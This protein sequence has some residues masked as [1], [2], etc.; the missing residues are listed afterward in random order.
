MRLLRAAGRY[1]DAR[2]RRRSNQRAVELDGFYCISWSGVTDRSFALTVRRPPHVPRRSLGRSVRD[3]GSA[4]RRLPRNPIIFA[5]RRRLAQIARAISG[6]GDRRRRPWLA[7]GICDA[8]SFPILPSGGRADDGHRADNQRPD[9]TLAH[10]REVLPRSS[11]RPPSQMYRETEPEPGGKVGAATEDGH[12][13]RESL[14]RHRGDPS[15][16]RHVWMPPF[17]ARCFDR[18]GHVIGAVSVSG[19]RCGCYVPRPVLEMPHG[20]DQSGDFAFDGFSA[21]LVRI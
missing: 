16:A 5:P 2:T 18:L 3:R 6:E 19:L 17:R 20:A 9:V 11:C 14:N 15:R 12:R 13:R 1:G 10:L 4:H 8:A 7:R 21:F